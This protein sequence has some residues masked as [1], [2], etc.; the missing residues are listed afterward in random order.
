[1]ELN[2]A[3]EKQFRETEETLL[4]ACKAVDADR[5]FVVTDS[6]VAPMV[7]SLLKDCPRLVIGQ[8][9]EN[10]TLAGA[11]II[12]RFLIDNCAVRRSVLVNIGGGMVSDLG[13]FA[14]AT[15]KRG[16]RYVNLPTTL[17]A[18]VDASIGG[19]TA[20]N[21]AG[22][23]NEIGAFAMPLTVL[24]LTTLFPF[25][26]EQEWLSGVGEAVKTALLVSEDLFRMATSDSF[27]IERRAET[28]KEVTKRCADFKS[29]IVEEDFR[30]EGK[31]KILNL[32]HTAGHGIEAWSMA[33]GRP[34]PHGI[35]VAYG[36]RHALGRS[37][38]EAGL[39]PRIAEMYEEFLEKRFP[40]LK[41]SDEDWKEITKYMAHDKKNRIPGVPEWVL[42]K[43][44]GDP[45]I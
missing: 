35:A 40:P 17:L 14:A 22:I 15:F 42:L 23:K 20:V 13:G 7:S 37:V 2:A 21:F 38:K 24:P 18:A 9:D 36:L 32:G 11:E 3:I 1:M 26:P 30:E 43:N 27:V 45:V 39:P 19:K 5:I 8:G 12:W 29:R 25:L 6:G 31:R 10:K 16:I 4:S 44:F 34:I 33:K 28:V 41:L